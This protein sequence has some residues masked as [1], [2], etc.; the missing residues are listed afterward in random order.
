MMNWKGKTEVRD[1]IFNRYWI[2][3][4]RIFIGYSMTETVSKRTLKEAIG[5][6]QQN[7]MEIREI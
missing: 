7:E 3:N 2:F 4:D 1:R 6:E 5:I